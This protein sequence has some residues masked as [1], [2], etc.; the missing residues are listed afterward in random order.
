MATLTA[1]PAPDTR[2]A[3]RLPLLVFAEKHA[4][5]LFLIALTAIAAVPRLWALG[6]I[7][8]GIHGDE[9]QVGTDAWRVLEDGWI[10]V[11]TLAALGQP[12]GHAYYAAPF[13]EI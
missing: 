3:S 12:A 10:G 8:P 6:E 1:V 7:P 13:I 4:D 2:T 11:Y 9:A 5:L